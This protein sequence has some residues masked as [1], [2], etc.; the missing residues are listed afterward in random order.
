MRLLRAYAAA[1]RAIV[2]RCTFRIPATSLTVLPSGPPVPQSAEHRTNV[3]ARCCSCSGPFLAQDRAF[4][5]AAAIASENWARENLQVS[6]RASYPRAAGA[7]R[8]STDC[9]G[10]HL[11]DC[12]GTDRQSFVR[13]TVAGFLELCVHPNCI[14]AK[15]DRVGGFPPIARSPAPRAE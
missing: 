6:T 1:A 3:T 14:A 5:A 13:H 10:A 11:L 4:V 15:F 7:V 12:Q 9:Q 2:V 8:K